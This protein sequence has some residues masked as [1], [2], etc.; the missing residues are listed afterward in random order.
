MI[1][2]NENEILQELQ[3][4]FE[5]VLH[6]CTV[7]LL[8]VKLVRCDSVVFKS[9]VLQENY[10]FD[11]DTQVKK[12]NCIWFPFILMAPCLRKYNES[13]LCVWHVE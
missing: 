3:D 10:L 8:Y 9:E 4:C 7:K 1:H 2:Q 11:Q 6:V 13:C 12:N 5:S